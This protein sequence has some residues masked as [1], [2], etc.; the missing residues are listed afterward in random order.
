ML[1][2]LDEWSSTFGY[3]TQVVSD[4]GVPFTSYSFVD[5]V[6]TNGIEHVW[7]T[8]GVA[9]GNGQIERVNRCI[10]AIISK[11]S[12][13]DTSK[14]YKFVPQVQRAINSNIHCSTKRTPFELMFGVAIHCKIS[15]KIAS[16]LEQELIDEFDNE[17]MKIRRGKNQYIA[18]S[19]EIQRTF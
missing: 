6:K 11:L 10:L 18:G 16:M 9:L 8:T 2:K 5:Y 3:P 4:R 17:R 13:D 7:T 19:E 1:K 15:G 12:A 14:W